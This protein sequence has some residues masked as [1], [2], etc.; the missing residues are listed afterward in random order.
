MI[1]GVQGRRPPWGGTAHREVLVSCGSSGRSPEPVTV[2]AC[3][4]R[5]PPA[6]GTYDGRLGCQATAA[7]LL[8]PPVGEA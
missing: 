6:L 5:G 1:A 4:P 2:A 8:A 3:A 7:G